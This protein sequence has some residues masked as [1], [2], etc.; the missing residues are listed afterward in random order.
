MHPASRDLVSAARV[1]RALPRTSSSQAARPEI[2]A[3]F[4]LAAAL[5]GKPSRV[6]GSWNKA[7]VL[8]GRLF[9]ELGNQ[10]AALGAWET[11]LTDQQIT[12]SRPVN[13][14]GPAYES[15]DYGAHG[16]FDSKAGFLS[17]DRAHPCRVGLVCF[18]AHLDRY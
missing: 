18:S 13:P 7:L 14:Y 5:D 4:I 11:Q 6:V 8:A 12:P 2:P 16:I 1:C 17:D 3:K 15:H 9:R 10:F